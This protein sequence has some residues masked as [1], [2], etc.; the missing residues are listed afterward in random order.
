M[1]KT[2]LG[3]SKP[4]LV[5]VLTGSATLFGVTGVLAP[6]VLAAAYGVPS[7]PHT[8]Q[9]LRL[10]GSR[11]LALAA[12]SSTARTKEET[13][14]VLAVSGGMNLVDVLTALASA[15]GTGGVTAARAATTSATF[16]ALSLVVRSLD[17]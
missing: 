15:R 7:S 17:D 10:F 4:T 14:R 6:R 8:I 11:M 3:M 12:W 1:A 13:D 16:G 9:L 2:A 5:Q